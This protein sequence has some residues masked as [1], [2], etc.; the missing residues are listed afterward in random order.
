MADEKE[1]TRQPFPLEKIL[2]SS[3]EAYL[4]THMDKRYDMVGV[5]FE[6]FIYPNHLRPT[7]SLEYHFAV[8][9]PENAEV[10]VDYSP[11]DLVKVPSQTGVTTLYGS[12]S[13]TALIPAKHRGTKH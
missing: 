4:A 7:N 8:E 1:E 6:G 11:S 5:H 9:V 12:A 10:V 2:T 13:G 3:A